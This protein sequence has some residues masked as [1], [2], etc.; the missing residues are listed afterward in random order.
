[1]NN[2][3]IPFLIFVS[4]LTLCGY[5]VYRVGKRSTSCGV[6]LGIALVVLFVAIAILTAQV[7]WQVTLR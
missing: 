2:T 5:A 1:M 7:T 4:I 3:P 6:T